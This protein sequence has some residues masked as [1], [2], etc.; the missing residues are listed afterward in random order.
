MPCFPDLRTS[1]VAELNNVLLR[2]LGERIAQGGRWPLV[3]DPG[4]I[5]QKLIQPQPQYPDGV[6]V[7]TCLLLSHLT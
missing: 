6:S 3:L 7:S 5:A 1:E 4:D 2:D